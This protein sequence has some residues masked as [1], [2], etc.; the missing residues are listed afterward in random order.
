MTGAQMAGLVVA[1][2]IVGLPRLAEATPEE[3][4]AAIGPVLQH[5][6]TGN[7]SPQTT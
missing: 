3:L 6:L 4:V 2:H 5:Y 1:R 7:L